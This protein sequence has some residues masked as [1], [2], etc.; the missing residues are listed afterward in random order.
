MEAG[1]KQGSGPKM[2]ENKS[3]QH[4]GSNHSGY[5]VISTFATRMIIV[6]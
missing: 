6:E 3:S 1:V 5:Q 2:K 4:V